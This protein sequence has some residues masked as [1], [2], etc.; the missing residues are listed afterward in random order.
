MENLGKAMSS[1]ARGLSGHG[2]FKRWPA[3]SIE[4]D[5]PVLDKFRRVDESQK[6]VRKLSS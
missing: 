3:P 6:A 1:V 5:A 2:S 4:F